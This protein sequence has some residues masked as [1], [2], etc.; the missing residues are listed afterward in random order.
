MDIASLPSRV[1]SD[2]MGELSI[3]PGKLYGCQTQRSIM[4][5]PI[6]TL[7]SR[8]PLPIVH[9]MATIKK[10]CALY[11][12]SIGKMDAETA[13]AIAKA[14]DEILAGDLDEH[15]PLVIYQTWSGTQTNMNVNEVLSNRAI[16]HLGGKVGSKSPV[17]P[18]DHCN[19]GQSSNDSFPTAMHIAC[20]KMVNEITL[21]GFRYLAQ[22]IEG[23]K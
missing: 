4:N 13:D 15:F 20:A 10:C 1:E 12:K 21:P 3:P 16:M 8:M 11:N 5:F 2:S 19:M 14:A 22:G 17:H 7:E 18:N 6:G 9:A 23:K